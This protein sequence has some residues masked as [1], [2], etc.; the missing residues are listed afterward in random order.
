MK[1]L[2]LKKILLIILHTKFTRYSVAPLSFLKAKWFL[3]NT[4]Q[5]S[6]H[7]FNLFLNI[8]SMIFNET[9]KKKTQLN[10]KMNLNLSRE[11][12]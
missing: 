11:L 6:H 4:E 10:K 7:K 8:C 12:F 3:K 2:V 9:K 1:K 5:N